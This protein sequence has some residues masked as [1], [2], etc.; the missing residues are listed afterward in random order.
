MAVT[1]VYTPGGPTDN[2][3]VSLA[4]ADAYFAIRRRTQTWEG[5]STT[6]REE[7]LVEA[8]AIFEGLGGPKEPNCNERRLFS[9][10][11]Y[12]SGATYDDETG[13]YTLNQAL[14]FPRDED[15][16]VNSNLIIPKDIQDA[17]CEQAFWQLTQATKRP[18]PF[19]IASLREL[20]VLD[21]SMDGVSVSVK[22]TRCPEEVCPL[23]WRTFRKY[24][25]Q[26]FPIV[27]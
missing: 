21:A 4:L 24:I 11:Q 17:I 2:S 6:D 19:N 12:D 18:D 3:Y 7:A 5:W 10:V 16:D 26:T 15:I 9:G 27:G 1:L 20:G 14:H 22:P 25:R 13:L 23:S 8:T